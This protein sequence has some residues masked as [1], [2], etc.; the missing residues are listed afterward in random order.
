MLKIQKVSIAYLERFWR[1][2]LRKIRGVDRPS[3]LLEIVLIAQSK[4][5]LQKL[6]ITLKAVA[7]PGLQ[8]RRN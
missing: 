6:T 1:Y 8:S 7:D 5:S 4:E 3:P 2:L